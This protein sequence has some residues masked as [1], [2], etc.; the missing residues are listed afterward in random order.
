MA[1]TR[2]RSLLQGIATNALWDGI[3]TFL[4]GVFVTGFAVAAWKKIQSG[5]MDWYVIGSLGIVAAVFVLV[6]LKPVFRRKEDRPE[7]TGLLTEKV[8]TP[9]EKF[10]ALDIQRLPMLIPL[11]EDAV[12]LSMTILGFLKELGPPPFPKYTSEEISRMSS[13][14]VRQLIER[15]DVGF[16]EACEFHKAQSERTLPFIRNHYPGPLGIWFD[17][18]RSK[19]ALTGLGSAIEVLRNR[20]SVEGLDADLLTVPIEGRYGYENLQSIASNLWE[21]AF[22]VRFKEL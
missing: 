5:A 2:R 4:S 7:P 9:L 12:N 8:A 15:N 6:S 3:K 21:L 14:T 13:E 1:R 17:V 22:R 19:Y 20:F 11:Q 18:V 16:T 10:D